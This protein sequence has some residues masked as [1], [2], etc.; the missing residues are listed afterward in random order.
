MPPEGLADVP[1][2]ENQIKKR[3]PDQKTRYSPAL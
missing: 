3:K 2:I 1:K